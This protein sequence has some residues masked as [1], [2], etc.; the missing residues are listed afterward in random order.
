MM[1]ETEA[2]IW[3]DRMFDKDDPR[4]KL[5]FFRKKEKVFKSLITPPNKDI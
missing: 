2:L 4:R 1:A 5:E 3:V